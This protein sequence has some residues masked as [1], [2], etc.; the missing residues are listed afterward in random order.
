MSVSLAPLFFVQAFRFMPRTESIDGLCGRWLSV[1]SEDPGRLCGRFLREIRMYSCLCTKERSV[2]AESVVD[3]PC[4]RH[5]RPPMYSEHHTR[6]S[7]QPLVIH[8][9]PDDVSVQVK[10]RSLDFP[11]PR[12]KCM[13]KKGSKRANRN[14][15]TPMS[16]THHPPS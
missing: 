16:N 10:E 14:P 5:I 8:C 7:I 1:L 11:D 12:R 9:I 13:L 6:P 2:P 15:H 4:R 3:C